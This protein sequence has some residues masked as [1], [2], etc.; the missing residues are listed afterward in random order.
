M[1]I[2]QVVGT[3]VGARKDARLDGRKL[4]IV[5]AVDRNG[6]QDTPE[7]VAVDIVGAGEGET[8]IVAE[9]TAARRAIGGDDVPIDAAVIAIVDET[10]RADA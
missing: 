2:G 6:A 7:V 4:L 8:V 9:G 3:V 10:Y 1:R 5:A